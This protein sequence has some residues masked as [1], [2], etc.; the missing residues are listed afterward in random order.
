MYVAYLILIWQCHPHPLLQSLVD[1]ELVKKYNLTP[2]GH[3]GSAR[4][5]AVVFKLASQLKP[6]V[7]HMDIQ[8]NN[9]LIILVFNRSRRSRSP[10]IT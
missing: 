3:G 5:A 10:T 9:V 7:A 2:P 6:E 4:D 8:I 1:D